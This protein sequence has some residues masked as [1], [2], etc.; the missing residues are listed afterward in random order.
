[1]VGEA[2]YVRDRDAMSLS[3]SHNVVSRSMFQGR[4][5]N[6]ALRGIKERIW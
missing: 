1:M 5:E 6:S 3:I 2:I 4:G